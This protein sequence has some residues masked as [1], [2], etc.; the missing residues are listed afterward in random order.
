MSAKPSVPRRDFFGTNGTLVLMGLLALPSC[1]ETTVDA[2]SS[3][4]AGAHGATA[5]MSN[6]GTSNGGTSGNAGNGGGLVASGGN[7]G[8]GASGAGGDASS[9][10]GGA[11]TGGASSGSDAATSDGGTLTPVAVCGTSLLIGPTK[12]PA[13][14]VTVSPGTSTIQDAIAQHPAGT[15]Y[16]LAAGTYV[17]DS[18]INPQNNDTFIGAPGAIIDGSNNQPVA[19]GLN[20]HA[21][22]VTIK[23]LTIQ[24]FAGPQNNGI[25]N[26]GQGA[27][28]T[29]QYNTIG[30]NPDT[31]GGAN[32]VELGDDDVVSYNCFIYNAQGGI[33]SAGSTG[34]VVDHN[35]VSH[36]GEGYEAAHNCGCASGMKF[37]TSTKVTVTNNWVHDNGAPAVWADTN[38]SFFL[39]ENN[40]IEN[41]A[42]EGIFY[43]ISY[44][45]VI[46]GNVLRHNGIA[47]NAQASD[48]P[49]PA[50]YVSESGGYDTGSA[51]TLSGVDVNGVLDITGNTFLDNA[52]GVVLYQN[53]GRCCGSQDGCDPNC[54]THPLYSEVDSHGNERWNTQNVN[55]HGNTFTDDGSSGCTTI[56]SQNNFCTV[57]G[58]FST[59]DTINQAIAFNQNNVFHDNVYT[60][61]WK[62]LSPDQNSSLL[63]PTAW[64][65]APYNQDSASVFH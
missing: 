63:S 12:A 8:S 45:A 56:S 15:T 61:P 64:Q 10:M 19:F 51:V 57:T 5:G 29:I 46:R 1:G 40:V 4:D 35:E 7:T 62:F 16:Y 50:I 26:Q 37:F 41:N 58:L 13:G 25:V 34:Y 30:N 11:G 54:G 47:G 6:G 65:A 55:V 28:W 43:E 31:N 36:N 44:N 42:V 32:G 60:G 2:T 22:G 21:S 24:H 59:A 38:N 49:E 9:G 23:Y 33:A 27:R 48:F 14:A 39:I 52:D 18:S 20:D 53:A 17:I 3:M